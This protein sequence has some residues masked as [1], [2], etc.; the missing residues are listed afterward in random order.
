MSY[1]EVV[2]YRDIIE[3]YPE[4]KKDIEKLKACKEFSYRTITKIQNI[5]CLFV[6][7][8]IGVLIMIMI[9]GVI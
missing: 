6:G 4:T 7:I 9:T 2:T 3:K 5:I 8:G 1:P